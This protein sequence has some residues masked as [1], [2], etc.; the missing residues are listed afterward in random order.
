MLKAGGEPDELEAAIVEGRNRGESGVRLQILEAEV[1]RRLGDF[2]RSRACYE[3]VLNV[4]PSN[5][6]ARLGLDRLNE[7]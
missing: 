4:E 1:A 2:S 7:A 5:P 3:Q 6:V